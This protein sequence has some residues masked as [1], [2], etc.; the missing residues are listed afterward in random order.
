MTETR[1][2]YFQNETSIIFT[3]S[4]KFLNDLNSEESIV[5]SIPPNSLDTDTINQ[6]KFLG[7]LPLR[8]RKKKETLFENYLM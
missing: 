4:V 8:T 7:T 2:K 5:N 1:S 6:N 3:E